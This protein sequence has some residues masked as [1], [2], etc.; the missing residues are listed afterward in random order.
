MNDFLLVGQV[1]HTLALALCRQG[2]RVNSNSAL[3]TCSLPPNI[4]IW[5]IPKY[6]LELSQDLITLFVHRKK[7]QLK[8]LQHMQHNF[9]KLETASFYWH[10]TSMQ[11]YKTIGSY[12]WFFQ[13][14]FTGCPKT[15]NIHQ[16]K[17]VILEFETHSALIPECPKSFCNAQKKQ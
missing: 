13:S 15:W 4:V 6:G 2:G 12:Q 10:L 11:L 7:V 8:L 16:I 5:K 3:K 17:K 9:S 1:C 14:Y